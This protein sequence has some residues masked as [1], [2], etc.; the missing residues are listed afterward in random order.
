[1]IIRR[2]KLFGKREKVIMDEFKRCF[3]DFGNVDGS[4]KS[5]ESL[6]KLDNK[7]LLTL[8][9]IFPNHLTNPELLNEKG[10]IEISDET[11]NVLKKLGYFNESEAGNITKEQLESHVNMVKDKATNRNKYIQ[12]NK[13]ELYKY[14][15]SQH[16]SNMLDL[17]TVKYF[18]HLNNSSIF[19]DEEYNLI[20]NRRL[21]E[22]I[23]NYNKEI[24]GLKNN[25]TVKRLNIGIHESKYLNPGMEF[26][27]PGKT[28]GEQYNQEL[29]NYLKNQ[30]NNI[31][32]EQD[33]AMV[34]YFLKDKG[35]INKNTIFLP[36]TRGY[37]G[38]PSHEIGHIIEESNSQH[39]IR[40]TD[41]PEIK[42]LKEEFR[43]TDNSAGPIQQLGNEGVASLRGLSKYKGED[44]EQAT[45]NLF[46]AFSTYVADN[47]NSI[48]KGKF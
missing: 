18:K 31:L 14:I 19:T 37:D 5:L 2:L 24:K 43:Y 16:G 12:E 48:M 32:D 35:N 4:Y 42:K 7:E 46:D 17:S 8:F 13:P 11:W 30:S 27:H 36:K 3:R 26:S 38:L 41:K 10:K 39:L 21:H 44:K 29:L 40:S 6:S 15:T 9:K 25:N 45:K 47:S 22:P 20:K 28:L 23:V 33:A 34:E 1:M